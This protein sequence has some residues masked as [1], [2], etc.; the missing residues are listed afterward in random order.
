MSKRNFIK[1]FN[2]RKKFVK[3]ELNDL[4][5]KSIFYNCQIKIRF[6]YFYFFIKDLIILIILLK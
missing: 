5:Y 2:F 1:D 6:V 3:Q 4:V